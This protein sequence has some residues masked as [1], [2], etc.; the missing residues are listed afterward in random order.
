MRS[1]HLPCRSRL[2]RAPAQAPPGH[3]PLGGGAALLGYFA[4]DRRK[5]INIGG[6]EPA[7]RHLLWS[8][9]AWA[10]LR[11]CSCLLSLAE[12]NGA[13]ASAIGVARF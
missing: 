10:P 13:Q 4:A 8:P 6:I 5:R 9:D 3:R 1:V 2:L 11:V 7:V 12:I